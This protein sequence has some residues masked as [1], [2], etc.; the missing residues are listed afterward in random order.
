MID[1]TGQVAWV[2]G[3]ARK[4]G[5]GA[6]V[7]RILAEHGADVGVVEVVVDAPPAAD[8]YE[9]SPERLDAAVAAVEATGRRALGM[10]IDVT[11]PQQ[12]AE[13]VARTVEALSGT[14]ARSRRR[15]PAWCA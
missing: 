1:F 14:S 10:A 6:A 12:V 3:A 11:D 8:T 15:A 7:A 5:M 13:S 9:A 2:S 4:P